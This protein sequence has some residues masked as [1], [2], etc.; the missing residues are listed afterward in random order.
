MSDVETDHDIRYLE[1]KNPVPGTDK[2]KF[3]DVG[4]HYWAYSKYY[5]DWICTKKGCGSAPIIST[6]TILGKHFHFDREGILSRTWNNPENRLR[7]ELDKNYKYYGCKCIADIELIW[8]RGAIA[9][10]KMHAEFENL[11]NLFE[12][13]KDLDNDSVMNQMAPGD[14]I[15]VNKVLHEG[16]GNGPEGKIS[17]PD[18]LTLTGPEELRLV[19]LTKK[20]RPKKEGG[21][22]T[23]I[24][25]VINTRFSWVEDS[26]AKKYNDIFL[27][28]YREKLHLLM[29]LKQFA[30]NCAK[31]GK[32]FY[33]TEL[34]MWHDVL[35]LSGTIDGLVYDE[36]DDSYIIIDWK[37]CK[38][39]VKGDP[40]PNN[41]R[42]KPI[43]LLGPASR[44]TGLPAFEGMRNND[45]N[46]YGCQLTLYKHM[47]QNMT[48]KRISGMF[49]VVVEHAML[50]DV[51][52][53]SLKE[54]PLTK[55]D[56][57]IAQVFELRARDMMTKYSDTMDD[58]HMDE[59]IK[60]FPKEPE[61][62]EDH[63][64]S[65]YEYGPV[66]DPP[67]KLKR[68]GAPVEVGEN[69]KIKVN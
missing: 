16:P 6:T 38:D 33:R 53:L 23:I 52:A 4:H 17:I 66:N 10:T 21:P 14:K 11:V 18:L 67:L 68:K 3:E 2:I 35:H 69:K 45:L 25:W 36:V 61:E 15:I 13:D 59:I 31:T 19:N 29:F 44:G 46:K 47:F 32:R 41:A 1:T 55:Y 51:G 49:L 57:A 42:A 22:Y 65:D 39:G 20:R 28:G 60:Y 37:R 40:N 26:Y 62:E 34:L 9:G 48:G 24:N 58:T 50:N 30:I 54:I 64:T 56:E 27:Q 63:T 12:K 8:S 7:M 5:E 43:H